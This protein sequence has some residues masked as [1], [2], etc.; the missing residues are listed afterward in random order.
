M[1]QLFIIFSVGVWFE[2]FLTQAEKI[3]TV[4]R[5][6][7]ADQKTNSISIINHTLTYY[8]FL[9]SNQTPIEKI[10]PVLYCTFSIGALISPLY[11]PLTFEQ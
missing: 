10:E 3:V 9:P 5:D 6:R 1:K 2:G 11:L 7:K 4:Y 8:S